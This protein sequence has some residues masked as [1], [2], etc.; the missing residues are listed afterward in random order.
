MQPPV[1]T[2]PWTSATTPAVIVIAVIVVVLASRPDPATVG[3]CS[4]LLLTAT[5]T[6]R[7]LTH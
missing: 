1:L 3:A 2:R 5:E 7:R 6:F 4:M